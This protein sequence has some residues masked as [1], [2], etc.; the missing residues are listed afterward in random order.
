MIGAPRLPASSKACAVARDATSVHS[1]VRSPL[2]PAS[3]P[4]TPTRS[5]G[6]RESVRRPARGRRRTGPR[7]ADRRADRA[8]SDSSAPRRCGGPFSPRPLDPRSSSR[9]SGR[10]D[11]PPVLEQGDVVRRPRLGR[12]LRQRSNRSPS[13]RSALKPSLP[14]RL[15]EVAADPDRG[16]SCIHEHP[17]GARRLGIRLAHLGLYPPTRSRCWPGRSHSP[18]T[19]GASARGR[20]GDDVGAA[21]G[22]LDV[23]GRFACHA[24]HRSRGGERL[25]FRVGPVSRSSPARWTAATSSVPG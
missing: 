9:S 20:R 16:L 14:D 4:H 22:S 24:V 15:E 7:C 13:I 18:R 11:R 10:G 5:K 2:S 8:V 17:R 6:R 12:P 23:G 19:S 25:R 3:L 1:P 21:T